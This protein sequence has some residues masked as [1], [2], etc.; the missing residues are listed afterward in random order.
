MQRSRPIVGSELM[1][2]VRVFPPPY[3]LAAENLGTILSGSFKT[4]GASLGCVVANE[5]DQQLQGV[6]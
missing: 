2:K 4:T 1:R 6:L 3:A 5:Q